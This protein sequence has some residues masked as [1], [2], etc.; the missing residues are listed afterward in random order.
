VRFRTRGDKS[1]TLAPE[2]FLRR[3]LMHVLPKGFVKIR[4][5]GLLASSHATTTLEIARAARCLGGTVVS[6]RERRIVPDAPAQ[7]LARALRRADRD[8]PHPLPALRPQSTTS[9]A[10]VE[11]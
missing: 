9:H 3:F 5:Y 6:T 7:G 11:P 4:Q 10:A 8:R 1:V 2:E